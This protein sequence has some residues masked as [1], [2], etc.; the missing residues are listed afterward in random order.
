MTLEL[1]C[2]KPTRNQCPSAKARKCFVSV[3]DKDKS[4][5]VESVQVLENLG[6]RYLPLVGLNASNRK[7]NKCGKS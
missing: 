1:L 6:F 5:I 7:R 4:H 2:K 3:K